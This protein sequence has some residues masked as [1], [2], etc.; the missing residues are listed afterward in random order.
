MDQVLSSTSKLDGHDG[1]SRGIAA[2]DSKI[3]ILQNTKKNLISK[4][5]TMKNELKE[6]DEKLKVTASRI[7][8][9]NRELVKLKPEN[10]S[11]QAK[12]AEAES[13]Y[14]QTR[15]NMKDVTDVQV[16]EYGV[17]IGIP[18]I[19][20]MEEAF[21]G[22]K[23]KLEDNIS[24]VNTQSQKLKKQLEYMG[25]R[26]LVKEVELSEKTLNSIGNKLQ[27]KISELEKL[28]ET[29]ISVAE[30][31]G[32]LKEIHEALVA[33]YEETQTEYKTARETK[34]SLL[35]GK[36]QV[37]NSLNEASNKVEKLRTKRHDILRAAILEEVKIPL[38]IKTGNKRPVTLDLKASSKRTR[39]SLDGSHTTGDEVS[40]SSSLPS[41]DQVSS[42]HGSFGFSQDDSEHVKFDESQAEKIDFSRLE[43]K[44]IDFTSSA[45]CSTRIK[46][47]KVEISQ[48]EEQL[49]SILPNMKAGE[50]FTDVSERLKTTDERLREAKMQARDVDERFQ[51]VK[52]KRTEKFI[53][54]FEHVSNTID[55]IY[56]ELTMSSKHPNGGNAYLSLESTDEPYLA[57]IKYH[58]MPPTKRFRDMEQ[59]SGGEK[60]VAALAL[61]FAIHSYHPAPFF[62]M[63]EVDAALDNVNVFKVSNY[64]RMHSNSVQSIVISLKDGFYDKANSLVGVYRDRPGNC[65]HTMTLSLDEYQ[66]TEEQEE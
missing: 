38:L 44:R 39:T 49:S 10:Q 37:T 46:E 42:G 31:V 52:E 28:S 66:A 35:S 25:N 60:T 65:S 27:A 22:E 9:I 4:L 15:V 14:S 8:D 11:L 45:V 23:S 6:L 34:E 40:E 63:D 32:S 61:L 55:K 7:S 53:R 41:A 57:G 13:V 54:M 58:T 56:K 16:D 12:M 2:G 26:K 43:K 20:Q 64:I 48:L 5:T 24:R 50:K 36:L 62:V 18:N 17:S 51:T 19:R 21:L 3:E 47:F 59:L 29:Q 1:R 33:E 30:A